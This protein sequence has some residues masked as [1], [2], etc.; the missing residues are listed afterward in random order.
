MKKQY[1]V[2][3][4]AD[5]GGGNIGDDIQ[6]LA[7]INLLK[8][9]GIN[10]YIYVDRENM[11]NYEG[12]P[13]YVIMNGWFLNKLENFPPANNIVPLFISFH[14][15]NE[16]LIKHNVQYFKK[17]E[18]IGCRD[19]HTKRLCKKYGIKAYF[20]GCITLTFDAVQVKNDLVYAVDSNVK[21][22][23]ASTDHAFDMSSQRPTIGNGHPLSDVSIEFDEDIRPTSIWH[24]P[25]EEN[26]K[27]S[28]ERRLDYAQSLLSQYKVAKLVI[29]SRLHAAMPCRAFGTDVIFVVR[30]YKIDSRFRG[31]EKI[32]NG[33][34][35]GTHLTIS[36]F[37]KYKTIDNSLLLET[38]EGLNKMFSEL[39]AKY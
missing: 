29:T 2:L 9:N 28:V 18:P 1:A 20:S 19:N 35:S 14:S 24:G 26:I 3:S 27:F 32:L 16:K 36:Q 8:K 6:T 12:P 23:N 34:Q 22:V 31:M 5:K 13:V 39:I 21:C 7:A 38:K 15:W 37:E 10:E 11:H 25:V 30:G 17:Y 33:V 4:Y